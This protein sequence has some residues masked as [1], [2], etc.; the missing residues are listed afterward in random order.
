[1]K[2]TNFTS[3]KEQLINSR[4]LSKDSD[5]EIYEEIFNFELDYKTIDLVEVLFYGFDDQSEDIEMQNSLLNYIMKIFN[6]YPI[7]EQLEVLIVNKNSFLP[8]AENWFLSFLCRYM[9]EKSNSQKIL[10][11]FKKYSVTNDTIYLLN[12][13][14]IFTNDLPFEE[15]KN[16]IKFLLKEIS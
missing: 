6:N 9:I 8:H 14:I 5:F 2:L 12:K 3:L 13:L 1:M 10:K 11:I 7:E 4:K 16:N 15:I